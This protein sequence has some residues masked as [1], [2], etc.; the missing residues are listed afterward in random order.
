MLSRAQGPD[1][2]SGYKRLQTNKN[3]PVGHQP[4]QGVMANCWWIYGHV[5]GVFLLS[6]QHL[7]PR[8]RVTAPSRHKILVVSVWISS[9]PPPIRRVTTTVLQVW[10]HI[11]LAHALALALFLAIQRA[12]PSK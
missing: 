2:A 7:C 3:K 11:A 9:L 12:E 5:N 4:T 10:L 8:I 6:G 1:M